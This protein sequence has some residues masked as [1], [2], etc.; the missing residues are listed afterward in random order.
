MITQLAG[1]ITES[2][3]FRSRFAEIQ[4]YACKSRLS[5]DDA[6]LTNDMICKLLLQGSVLALS[7]NL[8]HR[9]LAQKINALIFEMKASDEGINYAVQILSSRL[10]NYPVVDASSMVFGN[11]NLTKMIKAGSDGLKSIDPEII[12]NIVEEEERSLLQ[13]GDNN[14]HFNIYQKEILNALSE[15]AIVSFSAP[16]SFG[17]SFIVR[18]HIAR[19]F[20]NGYLKHALIIVPTKS[21]IDDFYEGILSLKKSLNID[22]DIYTHS[23]SIPNIDINSIYILTQERLLFLLEKNPEYVKAFQLVY[24]D[25]A[26]YISRGYRGFILRNVLRK[27]IE[28]CG[29]KN[30]NGNTQYIFTS[31]LIKNPQY[32]K[33]VFFTELGDTQCYHKEVLYS[34]VEKN[35]HLVAKEERSFRY[36]LLKDT[37]GNEIYDKRIEEIGAH[38]FEVAPNMLVGKDNQEVIRNVNIVIQSNLAMGTILYTTNPLLAHTYANILAEKL[39]PTN[40]I[41]SQEKNDIKRYIKDNYDECFGL[42]E[43][44]EKGIG[45]H[46]GPMPIGLR[47]L[48]VKL[49]E[50]S[51]INYLICTSTL[52]EGVNLPAKNIF[53]F[54]E[55]NVNNQK[56]EVLSFWNLIGRA[57]RITYGL[58]GDVFC[59]ADNTEKYKE[60]IENKDVE[61]KDPEAHVADGKTKQNYVIDS[62]ITSGKEYAYINSKNRNDIEYLIYEL[63][64]TKRI[65]NIVDRFNMPETKREELIKAINQYKEIFTIPVDLLRKNAGIDPRSQNELF[66]YLNNISIIQLRSILDI[67]VNPLTIDGVALRQLL[68]RT[69]RYLKWPVENRRY[70]VISSISNRIIQWMHELSISHFIQLRLRHHIDNDYLSKVDIA[71]RT[72]SDLEKEISF[73]APKYINCFYDICLYIA[74]NKNMTEVSD[75]VDRVESFLFAMESGITSNVGRFLYEK[76]VSRPIAIRASNLVARIAEGH[77]DH[78]YFK[79]QE[80]LARL[81]AELS[82]IAFNELIEHLNY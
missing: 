13:I 54:S 25:E 36:Y 40:K 14:Y 42:I 5:F 51:V 20:Y 50:D 73:N 24:I 70:D 71:L 33:N 1:K 75:Y 47:R 11:E 57:G 26:H 53:I 31:P 65:N 72:V 74:K 67:T 66:I 29:V 23:R 37:P 52:L 7:D 43:L 80:V 34:P 22:C 61:I 35:I 63:L 58:S 30:H 8:Y 48:M 17:K 55:K 10:G 39:S 45:L 76:G 60:I 27:V 46:Y 56:H 69:A 12:G 64:T 32:F 68:E 59:I 28:L 4:S 18:H 82:S 79:R 49:F 78:N 77:I 19:Q 38:E 16:T 81:K 2:Q 9:N 15:K 62:F 41:D 6:T 21:L 3:T 44:I